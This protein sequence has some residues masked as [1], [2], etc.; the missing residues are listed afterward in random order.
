MRLASPELIPL[1]S[2]C[3]TH[4]RLKTLFWLLLFIPF[5]AASANHIDYLHKD[6][7]TNYAGQGSVAVAI[8]DM[9][10]YVLS[11]DK[12]PQ[13]VGVIRG[14]FGN[15][16]NV[17]TKSGK[18]LTDDFGASIA[19]A[20][21]NAGFAASNQSTGATETSAQ[22][23]ERLLQAKPDRIVIVQLRDWKTDEYQKLKLHYDI[24]V[25]VYDRAG[26]LLDSISDTAD[27]TLP[28]TPEF[29]SK[30]YVHQSVVA[31]RRKLEGWLNDDK[32]RIALGGVP[33]AA[34]SPSAP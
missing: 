34:I 1:T 27:E 25:S 19:A 24:T 16:G 4:V 18:A 29:I 13:F 7:K 31:Y 26:I 2:R 12:K 8:L 32:I 15:P 9:R 17:K 3:M 5:G 21:S 28:G 23:V 33:A 20:L 22:A 10:S 6:I 11:G 30:P 14:L